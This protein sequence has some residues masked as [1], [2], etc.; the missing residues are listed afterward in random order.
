M[1]SAK[2]FDLYPS[3]NMEKLDLNNNAD[4]AIFIW[5]EAVCNKPNAVKYICKFLNPGY[6]AELLLRYH[7]GD[8]SA[9]DEAVAAF[10]ASFEKWQEAGGKDEELFD[11]LLKT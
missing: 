10:V 1:S 5:R 8:E 6:F 11:R 3:K 9:Q 7:Q 2:S 4:A